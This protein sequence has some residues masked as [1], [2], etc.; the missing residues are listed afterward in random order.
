MICL[1]Q[2]RSNS[3]SV[4]IV[5]INFSFHNRPPKSSKHKDTFFHLVVQRAVS[6][7]HWCAEVGVFA[8]ALRACL[9][10]QLLLADLSS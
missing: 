9:G 1:S 8:A 7:I 10:R 2:K 4:T 5:S 6:V 3:V